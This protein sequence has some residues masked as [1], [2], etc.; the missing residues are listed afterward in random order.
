VKSL[1]ILIDG[2]IQRW[3]GAKLDHS[4]LV[5][6]PLQELLCPMKSLYN[7]AGDQWERR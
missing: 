2:N 6:I 1:L 7:Y 3:R 5:V 4:K